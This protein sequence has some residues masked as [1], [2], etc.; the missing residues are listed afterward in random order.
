MREVAFYTKTN[1]DYPVGDFLRSLP[2]KL[3][4]KV[5]WV[6]DIVE[7]LQIVPRQYFKKLTGTDGIWEVRVDTGS[8]TIRLLGFFHRGDLIVLTNGFVKKSQLTPMS[9]IVVAEKR[10]RE[11]LGNVV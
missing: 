8:V 9:E 2:S 5:T 3:R 6:L 11:Y 7:D 10:K 1:G 4:R